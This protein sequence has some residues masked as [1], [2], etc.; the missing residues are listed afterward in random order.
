MREDMKQTTLT[1]EN[2][3]THF[4]TRGGVAK[5]VDGV[6]FSIKAGEI[7]G[8]VGESG[9][10]KSMTGYSIMGL[11]DSPGEVIDGS[12]KLKGRELRGLPEAEMRAIRGD[13]IAMIFQDPMMTLNPV[14]RIDT[15][16]IE[17]IVAH[18]KVSEGEARAQARA[19][20]AR[21]GIPSPD[22][23]LLAYPHQFSGGMRQRVAIAIALL[24]EPDLIICD[25]P[26]TALDVTIQGQILYEMQKLCR[27]S[28]TALIWITHDLSVV[29]ALA[30]SVCVMY[31]GKIIES[32]SVKDVIERSTHPYTRGLIASA[33]SRNPR[34]RP[35]S[36]ISGSTPSLLNLPAGCAFR[37]R[38]SR[39]SADC[40][41]EP[42]LVS[43]GGRTFRCFHPF[44]NSGEKS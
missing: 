7:L 35:L 43:S 18:R 25:E 14:L 23:R 37:E 16:M 21:V 36:Q 13:R 26:T 27:E 40:L 39:A 12:I 5:A 24:N 11:I 31:A 42:V 15:Q 19:A 22:E 3:K 32:G 38:C 33:P 30:D 9:S 17:A 28:G 20:L 1:V 4:F 2:L 6:S 44:E 41:D 8:L 34:G 29:A 10:G